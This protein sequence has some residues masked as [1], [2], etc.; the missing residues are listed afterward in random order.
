MCSWPGSDSQAG[1][2][3]FIPHCPVLTPQP[4][5]SFA[6]AKKINRTQTGGRR[7]EKEVSKVHKGTRGIF[8]AAMSGGTDSTGQGVVNLP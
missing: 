1:S 3:N 2:W 4:H 6:G 8:C 5:V 7:L